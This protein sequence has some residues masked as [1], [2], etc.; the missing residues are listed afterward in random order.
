MSVESSLDNEHLCTQMFIVED[1]RAGSVGVGENFDRGTR[2]AV[3]GAE[4]TDA[5]GRSNGANTGS[6]ADSDTAGHAI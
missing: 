6:K 5:V 1:K 3:D 4:F 2:D